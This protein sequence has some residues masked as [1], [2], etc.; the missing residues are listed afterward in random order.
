MNPMIYAGGALG[1]VVAGQSGASLLDQALES[2]MSV[3]G[4]VKEA[5]NLAGL[6]VSATDAAVIVAV[7]GIAYKVLQIATPFAETINMAFRAKLLAPKPAPTLPPPPPIATANVTP[8][9]PPDL[10]PMLLMSSPAAPKWKQA[11]PR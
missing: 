9:S 4:V 10:R 7:A 11:P 2:D 8:A 6:G 1:L 3:Q 5:S